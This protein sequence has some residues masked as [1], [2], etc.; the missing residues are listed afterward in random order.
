MVVGFGWW[1]T[2]AAL[3]ADEAGYRDFS[4]SASSVSRP[5]G[6]RP[7]SKL[8]FN[9]GIWWGVL[10]NRSS[11]KHQIYR[12]DPAAHTWSDTG[13]V[14][15]ERNNSKA[16]V[17]WDGNRLYVA[18]AGPNAISNSSAR[19]LRYSYDAGAKRYSRD[20]GFPVNITSAGMEAIVV[21]K[22]TTGKLWVTYTQN[23]RV[24]VNH[25]L[26]GD[27]NWGVPFVLPVGGTSVDPDDISSVIAFGDQ[28]GVMWSNQIDDAFYFATHNDEEPADAWQ[29]SSALQG[30]GMADDHINLKTDSSGKVYAA[31]K[32][33][34]DTHVQNPDPNAPLDL[35]LVRGE[36]GSW[37]S[38]VF[39]R[40]ADN[41]TRPIVLIDEE[42]RD[43]YMFASSPCCKGG[44]IY[45]K[46]TS[47]NNISFPEGLG[48]PFIHT[49]TD[50]AL[51]DA[52]STK[53]NLNSA[54]GMLVEASDRTSGYYVHNRTNFGGS[55]DTTAPTVQPPEQ[56]FSAGTTLG[57]S[58]VPVKLNW[59]ATDDQSGVSQYRLQ[60]STN[61]GPY[62]NVSLSSPT[63]TS[64]SRSL[65]S[66]NAYTFR[67]RAQDG[68]GNW[69]DWAQEPE[70]VVDAHQESANAITYVGTWTQQNSA[71][72]Y[73]GSLKYAQANG[74][75]ARL[76]FI[77]RD[78]AWV[79]TKGPDRGKAEVWVDGVKV[80]S[81]DLYSSTEQPRKVVSSVHWV[82]SG[83][84]TVE[85]RALG[86]K[87]SS[88]TATRVD[89]DAFVV[90]RPDT[91]APTI[92][93]VA[94]QEGASEVALSSNVEVTFSEAMDEA[95][96]ND[97]TFTLLEQSSTTP[98]VATVTYDP[99]TRTVTLDPM[100][101]LDPDAS[102]TATVK[103]GVGGV[104]DVA[105]NPLAADKVWSFNT[106]DT[107]PP[108]TI[109]DSGPSG[110]V[111]DASASFSF[112]SSEANSTFECSLDGAPFGSCESPTDYAGL[113][114]GQHTFEV[115]AIDAADNSDATP[116]KSIW[117]VDT[118]TPEASPR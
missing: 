108:E 38:H 46:R 16:D 11:E 47:L 104:K 73:G 92:S 33:S 32:T 116:A 74:A 62:A 52:T 29:V 44:S 3:A 70:F 12:Y 63:T 87:N 82:E 17:L 26:N 50:L 10:F 71:S 96:L 106:P 7:Q 88:S 101:D 118:A 112:S 35:L 36:D 8:W 117:T 94:P 80:K 61:G 79:A 58:T 81:L 55:I 53:Q 4:F 45:F 23:S 102:Y 9:D 72:A 98:V 14:V 40:V 95:S 20:A 76:G 43:L 51:D 69:S 83:A 2:P 59:S 24:Y 100:T 89:V 85:V 109:I 48:V 31:V 39:G 41:S 18:S 115:R 13:T 5:T 67:V 91:T 105:G 90:L 68:A 75:N 113:V 54:T 25:T 34:L 28:V 103:G 27:L 21:A 56:S 1:T 111:G 114:D 93:G 60:Q 77:G 65:A 30:K 15:D 97:A 22:D 49:A 84:H 86:K 6:E 19:I 78:V 110:T 107:T 37:A 99:T 57:T 42:D 66:G 64:T